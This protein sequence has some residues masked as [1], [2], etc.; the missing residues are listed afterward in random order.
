MGNLVN[1]ELKT[2]NPSNAH[3]LTMVATLDAPGALGVRSDG[4]IFAGNGDA[5]KIYTI[6]PITGQET[7]VGNTGLNFVGD[8]DFQPVPEPMSLSMCCL[9]LVGLVVY[10]RKRHQP[11]CN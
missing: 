11:T 3:T 1:T 10:R 7:T 8:L 4:T 9:G 2:L 5:G 6:N